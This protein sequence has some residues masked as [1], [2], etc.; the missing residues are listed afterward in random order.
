MVQASLREGSP[1]NSPRFVDPL[2]EFDP[3]CVTTSAS[4]TTTMSSGGG[5]DATTTTTTTKTT[6]TRRAKKVVTKKKAVSVSSRGSSTSDVSEAD[7]RSYEAQFGELLNETESPPEGA[8]VNGGAYI[9][10]E[11]AAADVSGRFV[12]DASDVRLNKKSSA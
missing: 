5:G 10:E 12:T 4:T 1:G 2:D 6:K 8:A 3:F 11:G 7:R 9:D